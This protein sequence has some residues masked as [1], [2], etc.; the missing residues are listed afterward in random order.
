V[1]AEAD[2]RAAIDAPS[3]PADGSTRSS[4]TPVSAGDRPARGDQRRGLGPD[5]GG[6]PARR[7]P[8]DQARD[9][10][11]RA[12]GGGSI[13]STASVAGLR[14]GAGPHSYSAAKAGV[15]NLT[16]TAALELAKDSIRVNCICPGGIH[17]RCSRRGSG[18][19]RGADAA[20]VDDPAAAAPGYPEDIAAMAL[21]LASDESSFV[22]GPPW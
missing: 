9:P 17:T 12:A 15:V 2:V 21:F 10:A 13:I 1:T 18:R 5:A 22:T 6:A 20:V 14:G 11:L 4:T 7:V 8:R 16:R 3:R 19:Q